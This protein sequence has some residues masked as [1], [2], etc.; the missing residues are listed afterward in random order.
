VTPEVLTAQSETG[1]I[2]KLLLRHAREAFLDDSTID[3]QWKALNFSGPPDRRRAIEEYDGFLDVLSRCA[4]ELVCLPGEPGLTLDSIYIRDA[5]VATDRGVI[6]CNMGKASRSAEPAALGRALDARGITV[7]GAIQPPGRLEG[8]D[9]VWLGA[10]TIAVGRGYRTNDEGIRQL[11][12]LLG[13]AVEDLIV[14]PLPH[15]R[16]ETDVFHLMSLISPVDDDLA[17]VYPPLMPVPF[18]EGLLER[19]IRLVE[20]PDDEFNTMGANVLAVAPR[21]CVMLAGNPETRR[22]LERAG[23]TVSEYVGNEISLKGGGG[24]TCLTRPLTRAI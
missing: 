5:A 9:I 21:I 3:S 19:G 13:P 10:H 7:A 20:V 24:P 14:V 22:R 16:G 6:L 12:I 2:Q 1:R 8:G 18:R 4:S 11:R 15:W 23:A 17:V